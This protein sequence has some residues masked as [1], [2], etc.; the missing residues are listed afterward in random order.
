MKIMHIKIYKSNRKETITHGNFCTRQ[1]F[2]C[3]CSKDKVLIINI[4]SFYI[5]YIV[6]I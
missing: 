3:Q 5:L 1:G 4:Y 6:Y 2:H